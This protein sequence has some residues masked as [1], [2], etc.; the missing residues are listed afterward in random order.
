MS[1]D[2]RLEVD[3]VESLSSWASGASGASGGGAFASRLLLAFVYGLAGLA[4]DAG[5]GGGGGGEQ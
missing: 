2:G 4:V 3:R 5:G 1:D